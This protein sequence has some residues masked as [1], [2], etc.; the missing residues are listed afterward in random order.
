MTAG[1]MLWN[2]IYRDPGNV[3]YCRYSLASSFSM[4]PGTPTDIVW[5]TNDEA[6]NLTGAFVLDGSSPA[7]IKNI[8][9]VTL[10]FKVDYWIIWTFGSGVTRTA[11]I[12]RVSDGA[13]YALT[14]NRLAS[15]DYATMSG[16]A[17]VLVGAGDSVTIEVNS[18]SGLSHDFVDH[19]NIAVSIA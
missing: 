14:M 13:S 3:P 15:A 17:S 1:S 11:K 6:R 5:D 10:L 18:D 19:G 9:S 2:S 7:R 8:S 12:K 16:S 4:V